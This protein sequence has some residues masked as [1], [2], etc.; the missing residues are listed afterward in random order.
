MKNLKK[1]LSLVLALAMALSLMTVA[2]AKDASDYNDY[3]E[4]TYKEAVDIMTAIGVFDGMSATEFAPDGTLTREQAAKIIT[5]MIMGKDAADRLTTVIAPYSD[6]SADRWSAGA[7][8]YCTNEGII[9]GMGNNRFAPTDPVTGLQFGKMLLVALGYDPE[10]EKLTGDSWAINVSKLAISAG[11]DDNVGVS[12]SQPLTREQAAQMA[13]NTM[14]ANMVDYDNRGTEIDL[15]GVGSIIVGASNPT[16]IATQVGDP[17]NI[18]ADGYVQFAERYCEDLI[19]SSSDTDDDYAR[20][21]RNWKYDGDTYGPYTDTTKVIA[22]W[23]TG[24]ED[25]TLGDLYKA[26]GDTGDLTIYMNG[27]GT[28]IEVTPTKGNDTKSLDAYKGATLYAVDMNNDNT[29]DRLCAAYPFLAQVT[30]VTEATD[31]ADRK[32]TLKV[33]NKTDGSTLNGVTYETEDFAKDDYVMVYVTGSMATVRGMNASTMSGNIIEVKAAETVEGQVTSVAGTNGSAVTA[34]TVAGTKYT[35]AGGSLANKG[36]TDSNT[37][38]TSSFGWNPTYTL[39][40][41]NGY[42]MGVDGDSVAA[43]IDNI[44]YV[45]KAAYKM[46]N[47]YGEEHWYVETIALDGTIE[48]LEN[49]GY[50]DG[51]GDRQD[52][53]G[54]YASGS[55]GTDIAAGFYVI[56]EDDGAYKFTKATDT[57]SQALDNATYY[58]GTNALNV[59]GGFDMKTDTTSI[60]IDAVATDGNTRAYVTDTTRI[61][62]VDGTG[63]KLTVTVSNGAVRQ[64]IADNAPVLLSKDGNSYV[65]EAIIV[66]AKQVS[67]TDEVVYVDGVKRGENANGNEYRMYDLETG[68]Y[69]TVTVDGTVTAGYKTYSVDADGVYDFNVV[70]PAGGQNADGTYAISAAANFSTYNGLISVND[71]QDIVDLDASSAVIINLDATNDDALSLSDLDDATTLVGTVYVQDEAVIA[72]VVTSYVPAV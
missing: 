4:V 34:L 46:T 54:E 37:V 45:T 51:S 40:L 17:T 6:V 39:F 19:L 24:I 18:A 56:D 11:L 62:F 61:L 25:V 13:F 36:L 69:E 21:A 70:T 41:S 48:I 14:V 20:P 59:S 26:L 32:V 42:V 16:S 35:V 30:K 2:F 47:D 8:A 72:I 12:L 65:V 71:T 52:D 9:S 50:D 55:A 27:A 57:T 63:S 10:I 29:A 15:P 23:T 49:Y 38:A 28:S 58:Y 68:E 22:T 44:V 66:N 67:A 5:Y 3:D 64:H 60:V 31:S 33:W 1:V 53:N 43:D 7:I